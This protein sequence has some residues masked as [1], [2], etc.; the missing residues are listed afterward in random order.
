MARNT[1]VL[2]IRSWRLFHDNPAVV[3]SYMTHCADI[4]VVGQRG[5]GF[6][7][8]V[9]GLAGMDGVIVASGV[10]VSPWRRASGWDADG[11]AAFRS[12]SDW[13]CGVMAAVAGLFSRFRQG[14]VDRILR[15]AMRVR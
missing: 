9:C 13:P 8:T 1:V 7:V 4:I 5:S 3:V 15:S 10:L 14:V 2:R 12:G 11:P 6:A